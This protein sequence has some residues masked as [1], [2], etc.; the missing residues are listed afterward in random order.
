[1]RFNLGEVKEDDKGDKYFYVKG[2]YL[3]FNGKNFG[4]AMT[5]ATI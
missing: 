2:R 1:M 5:T 3:D 4:K